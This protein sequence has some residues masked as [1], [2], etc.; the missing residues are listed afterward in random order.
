MGV[1]NIEGKLRQNRLRWFG[2]V[3]GRG[4]K[5][6]IGRIRRMELAGERSR[7]RPK[8]TWDSVVKKD[9]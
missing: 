7:G 2:H 5:E 3:V 8:L 6:E 1:E 4:E 9:M